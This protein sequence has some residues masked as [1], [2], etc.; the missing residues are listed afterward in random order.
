[1]NIP[2][3]LGHGRYV[4]L[5]RLGAGGMGVVYEALDT[6]RQDRIALKALPQV[7]PDAL[8]RFKYEFRHLAD[9]THPNLA[10]L[11]E[12]FSDGDQWFITMELVHGLDF[13]E[14]VRA[15]P[16]ASHPQSSAPADA[17]DSMPTM[18]LARRWTEGSAEG[19]GPPAAAKVALS[20]E[21]LERLRPALRQLVEA[22]AALHAAGKLHCDIKPSNVLVTPEGRVVLLDFGLATDFA[23]PQGSDRDRIRG[24]ASYMSPEQAEGRPLTPASDWYAVGTMLFEAL[25]ERVPFS[26][27]ALE[28][29][30]AKRA[31]DGPAPSTRADGVPEDLDRLCLDLL[32][33]SPEARPRGDQILQKVGGSAEAVFTPPLAETLVG[34]TG[35]LA[36]LRSALE[37]A[38][39]G[40][41]LTVHVQGESGAG[42]SFLVRRFLAT[43]KGENGSVVLSGRCYEGESVPYK[44]L[45]SVM[46]GLSTFLAG[47]PNR[48]AGALMPRD[49][50][51]LARIFPVMNGVAAVLEAPRRGGEVPDQIE[52]RRRAFAAFRDLLARIGDRRL[53]IL[54]ID[55]LHWGD[56]DSAAL[57]TDLLRPPDAPRLLLVA[58]YRADGAVTSPFL[59]S[60]LAARSQFT[61]AHRDIVVESLE[62]A[63]ALEL[64]RHLL[65]RE[66]AFD[67]KLAERIAAESRGV[68]Y[69]VHE[70]VRYLAGTDRRSRDAAAATTL[71]LDDVL[72]RRLAKLGEDARRLLETIAISAVPLSQRDAHEAAELRSEARRALATLRV[73]RLVKTTGPGE[74]DLV[75]SYHDRIRELVTKALPR[76]AQRACHQRLAA[77]LEA[78]GR[79][80]PEALGVHFEGAGQP[81]KAGQYYAVA[82]QRASEAL[83]FD[84]AARLLRRSL[85]LRPLDGEAGATLRAS[86]GD[87]LANAGR[88]LEAAKE[89]DRA[90]TQL[91]PKEAFDLQIKAAYQYCISGHIDEGR[92]ALRDLLGRVGLRMPATR[93]GTIARLL[94]NRLRLTLRGTRYKRREASEVPEE[95]LRRTDVT[96]AASAG[97]SMFDTVAGTAFQSRNLLDALDS[98]EPSRLVRAL[99]WEAVVGA[100]SGPK[101]LPAATDLLDAARALAAETHDPYALGMCRLAGGVVDFLAGNWPAACPLLDEAAEVFRSRC[102]G[103]TWETN[104][105]NSF[106]MWALV[107]RGE[108]AAMSRR[109]AILLKEADERGDRSASTTME[110]FMIAHAHLM[111]DDPAA[112]RGAVDGA[113]QR[114]SVQGY[115]L[116]HINALWMRSYIDFYAGAGGD[117][118]A[119]IEREWKGVKQS[120]LLRSLV[121]RSF[122]HYLRARAALEATPNSPALERAAARD[123]AR[124]EAERV[125]WSSALAR[126]VRAGVEQRRGRAAA[127]VEQLEAAEV[128]LTAAG[129]AGFAAS[130]RRR[131]GELQ[132]GGEGAA[133][134][135]EADHWMRAQGIR[136]PAAMAR[137]HVASV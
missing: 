15:G 118:H 73:A 1:M 128:A 104:T 81:E 48:D 130:A 20:S 112:A 41:A 57:L 69:F 30:R 27:P 37:A 113:L 120:F 72:S 74:H 97:L 61:L 110:S 129:M 89:Y 107:H 31:Q 119:R 29:L 9:V 14:Y 32:R 70:L 23:Q 114:F 52:L 68:P 65:A 117:A 62:F 60:F 76:E 54:I 99:A 131:R 100:N 90:R 39:R 53:V 59:R 51:A 44:A 2:P 11:Y 87:A 102:T 126:L 103:V 124:L 127:A 17:S 122:F 33:R 5:R 56:A 66:G 8:S 92:A 101:A 18:D 115:Q 123:A 24:T 22:V 83:A 35:H 63:D 40:G 42:K 12:L 91:G 7:E 109:S 16:Y 25:A 55:D 75:E 84:R 93:R 67:P 85:E 28:R 133:A 21:S 136:N 78:S 137:L 94:L 108:F 49:I 10:S 38:E 86:L 125:P 4:I 116:Q 134:V 121:I 135:E 80:D 13:C 34:R 46:D 96:W 79:A 6:E 45:D 95:L 43:L 47:L 82:G 36:Q 132:G 98:G 77:T 88:G 19:S 111:N 3:T 26:G 71:T 105:A 58:V 106:N 64:A 50:H